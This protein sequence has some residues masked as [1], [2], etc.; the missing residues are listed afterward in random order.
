ML[1]SYI[2]CL[3]FHSYFLKGLW[4]ACTFMFVAALL[5]LI[6]LSSH[7]CL[8]FGKL[9]KL[10]PKQSKSAGTWLTHYWLQISREDIRWEGEDPGLSHRGGHGG[11]QGGRRVKKSLNHGGVTPGAGRGRGPIKPQSKKE[12]HL[13]QNGVGKKMPDDLELLN[14]DTL[15]KEVCMM[16]MMSLCN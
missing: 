7:I 2:K 1:L 16:N 8:V 15:V 6:I 9:T 3:L 10:Y 12:I 5:A 14:T 11:G 13:S 4:H